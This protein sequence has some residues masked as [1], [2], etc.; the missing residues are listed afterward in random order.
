[1]VGAVFAFLSLGSCF[2][3]RVAGRE[4]VVVSGAA[5]DW[6]WRIAF[7]EDFVAGLGLGRGL[8]WG[9]G[10]GFLFGHGRLLSCMRVAGGVSVGARKRRATERKE[11]A[12]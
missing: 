3:R 10:F 9:F 6:A 7:G 5:F 12:K 1:L 11:R 2:R 8:A 4:G